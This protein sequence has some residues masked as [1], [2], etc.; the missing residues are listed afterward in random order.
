MRD[1]MVDGGVILILVVEAVETESRW[2]VSKVGQ[3]L[4]GWYGNNQQRG[5]IG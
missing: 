5:W 1:Q 3:E 2:V 4:L